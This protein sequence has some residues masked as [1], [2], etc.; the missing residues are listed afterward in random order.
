MAE[1]E[2]EEPELLR[3]E[4]D[5]PVSP[6]DPA[7]RGIE[8]EVADGEHG[9][10]LRRPSPEERPH[11]REE[12]VEGERLREVVVGAGVQARDAVLDAV[13]RREHEDRRPPVRRAQAPADLEPVDVGEHHVEQDHV[14]VVLGAEPRAVLARSRRRRPR[15][16]PP[17]AP[18][19]GGRPSSTRLRPRARASSRISMPQE[20]EERMRNVRGMLT[21]RAA[22]VD[23]RM[24]EREALAPARPLDQ[25][26]RATV[27]SAREAGPAHQDEVAR[28]RHPALHDVVRIARTA[29]RERRSTVD[30]RDDH[31]PPVPLAVL[32]RRDPDRAR[33]VVRRRRPRWEP[34][35][36]GRARRGPA[37]GRRSRRSRQ[38]A[39]SSGNP[40]AGTETS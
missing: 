21:D 29:D 27:A 20:D 24:P 10:A 33:D 30:G 6:R 9:R 38:S 18:A 31:Q 8:D 22:V 40:L 5:L 15:T 26:E 37:S 16:L 4:V 3:G 12:L 7:G 23:M 19:G 36:R 17:A 25:M 13:P 35:S 11:A 2:L 34:R 32:V 1:E 28:H 14:V 39:V